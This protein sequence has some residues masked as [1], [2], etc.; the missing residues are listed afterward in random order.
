[1][2]I[3]HEAAPL[4]A[5]PLFFCIDISPLFRYISTRVVMMMLGRISAAIFLVCSFLL[6]FPPSGYPSYD[7]EAGRKYRIACERLD[8]LKKSKRKKYRSY[9]MDCVRNFELVE[10]KYPKS[11]SAGDACF[12]KAGLYLDMYGVSRIRKDVNTS[13]SRYNTCLKK[14]PRHRATPKAYYSLIEIYLDYKKDKKKAGK[15]YG[16]LAQRYPKSKW[17]KRASARFGLSPGSRKQ[18]TQLRRAPRK[19]GSSTGLVTDIRH[20]S[21][22]PYTRIVVDLNK[23]FT[24][25]YHELRKPDRLVFDIKKA[26]ID[27]ALEIEP[28]TVNDGVLKQIRFSQYKTDTVRV[29]LDLSSLESYMAFPLKGHDR[30]VIDVK[31]TSNGEPS[32]TYSQA[33]KTGQRTGKTGSDIQQ[34]RELAKAL[35][36]GDIIKTIA[37]D[38]GHGGHDPGAIGKYGLKEKNI[39]LDIARRL[40]RLIKKK[41]NC[42]VVM[43]RDKDTF[44]DLDQR[45]IIAKVQR[46]DLFISVHANAN[47]S[48]RMKGIETYIQGLEATDRGASM[49]AAR[50]NAYAMSTKTHDKNEPAVDRFLREITWTAWDEESL[51]LAHAVQA[52]LVRRVKPANSRVVDLGVKRAFFYVLINTE[53]P[54]IL[55]EVGF[56]SNPKEERLLR[57]A[58]Y[59]QRIAEALYRGV[60]NYVKGKTPKMAESRGR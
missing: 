14:Y 4:K 46:A 53:M 33:N 29:V 37:I 9:W 23:P 44:I 40:S 48:R 19:G 43:I 7:S 59:R 36:D 35:K 60:K 25:K 47:R 3:H 15:T 50:E 55:A 18:K 24:F 54:S 30:L 8:G 45:P 58:V 52:S 34:A 12:E 49:T 17:T 16:T 38:A 1:V 22:G 39:T 20:R 6:V 42:K 57:K 31:G 11:P 41:L 2:N 13:I 27:T 56:I 32:Q 5:G 10:K 28:V 51:Q 21:G 26:R